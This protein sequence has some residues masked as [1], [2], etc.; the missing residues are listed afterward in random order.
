MWALLPELAGALM[1]SKWCCGVE[2]LQAQ[3]RV[4]LSAG[5]DAEAPAAV[6]A[7]GG[8]QV[9]TGMSDRVVAIF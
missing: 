9:W 7:H 2:S 6:A 8:K 5:L 1:V 4:L 3:P